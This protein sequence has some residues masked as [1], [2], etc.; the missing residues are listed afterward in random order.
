[1]VVEWPETKKENTSAD[2]RAIYA[3]C[4]DGLIDWTWLYTSVII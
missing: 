4:F 2:R 3:N 1:M